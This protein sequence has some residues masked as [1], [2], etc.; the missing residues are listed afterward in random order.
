MSA[1]DLLVV[2]KDINETMMT[3]CAHRITEQL[4][5]K[6][7]DHLSLER[8]LFLT[9]DKNVQQLVDYITT[10]LLAVKAELGQNRVSSLL[11]GIAARCAGYNQLKEKVYNEHLVK[12]KKLEDEFSGTMQSVLRE[13]LE[14][15]HHLLDGIYADALAHS[16]KYFEEQNV[17]EFSME[18]RQHDERNYLK[19][20]NLIHSY[21]GVQSPNNNGNKQL[22]QKQSITTHSV[23]IDPKVLC[24]FSKETVSRNTSVPTVPNAGENL[25]NEETQSSLAVVDILKMI[26]TQSEGTDKS[27]ASAAA[28]RVHSPSNS[29]ILHPM[30]TPYR[31]KPCAPPKPPP[32]PPQCS[33]NKDLSQDSRLNMGNIRTDYKE[34]HRSSPYHMRSV[35]KLQSKLNKKKRKLGISLQPDVTACDQS[36]IRILGLDFEGTSARSKY[37]YD[38]KRHRRGQESSTFDRV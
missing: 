28:S 37:Q 33:I 21:D 38:A 17:Q 8:E 5:E 19:S 22:N 36:E 6:K 30:A 7:G 4:S 26:Q 16:Q 20:R 32:P 13:E 24:E 15:G 18:H 1:A 23:S 10:S 27:S 2:L 29:N 14:V 31:R 35:E 3:K 12:V 25:R 9:M 34:E 11:L